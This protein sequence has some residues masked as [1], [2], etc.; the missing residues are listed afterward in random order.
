MPFP[1]VPRVVYKNNPLEEVI[2]QIRFPTVL[3]IDLEVPVAFQE[4]IRNDYP[5]FEHKIQIPSTEVQQITGL[6]ARGNAYDFTSADKDWAISL[7]K[8]FIALTCRQYKRWEEFKSHFERPIE[9]LKEIYNPP[10]FTRVGLRYQNVIC[11]SKLG[12]SDCQWADLLQPHIAGEFGHLGVADSVLEAARQT[13]IQLS[14]ND[15][16]VR[17]RHGTVQSE[18][19]EECYLIDN[20]FFKTDNVEVKDV[21]GLLGRL[22]RR[23]GLL[24]QWCIT[25]RL[26]EALEPVALT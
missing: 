4:Q 15:G 16:N 2:C 13:L 23:S 20:D 18:N 1:D 8:D 19:G 26:H 3:K 10:F 5:I 17:I 7:T 21:F 22:N 24:F 14:D 25:E 6:I 9:I 11:R 12:L